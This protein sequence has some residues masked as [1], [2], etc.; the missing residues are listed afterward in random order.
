MKVLPVGEGLFYTCKVVRPSSPN[1]LQLFMPGFWEMGTPVFPLPPV[2]NVGNITYTAPVKPPPL[3]PL[4]LPP[5]GCQFLHPLHQGLPKTTTNS[6]QGPDHR[7]CAH[8]LLPLRLLGHIIIDRIRILR[9]SRINRRTLRR[10]V[11]DVAVQGLC[12]CTGIGHR[13]LRVLL[14]YVQSKKPGAILPRFPFRLCS[15]A[16]SPARRRLKFF[17]DSRNTP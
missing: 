2:G 13:I 12:I 15:Q 4:P 14:S 7:R 9:Y 8:R 1:L 11:L 6:G 3:F 10:D 17:P 16:H 5:S